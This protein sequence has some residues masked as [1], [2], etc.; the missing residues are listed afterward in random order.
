MLG[1]FFF[2]FPTLEIK[3]MSCRTLRHCTH[4]ERESALPFLVYC[5]GVRTVCV[6]IHEA[7]IQQ[8]LIK[9]YRDFYKYI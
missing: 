1:C 7:V 8:T 9:M 2:F 5:M 6:G 3:Q 4:D